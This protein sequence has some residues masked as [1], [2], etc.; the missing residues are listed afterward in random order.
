[1]VK[2]NGKKEKEKEKKRNKHA[3]PASAG[4]AGCE[5]PMLAATAN[6]MVLINTRNVTV[7]LNQRALVM[8]PSLEQNRCKFATDH[9]YG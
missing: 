7:R 9:R 8:A 2:K 3:P 6:E 1:M 4:A 5:A